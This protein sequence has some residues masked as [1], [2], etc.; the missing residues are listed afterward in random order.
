MLKFRIVSTALLLRSFGLKKKHTLT[1]LL[2]LELLCLHAIIITLLLGFEIFFGLLI[3][4]VGACEGAVGLGALVR[5]IRI[6]RTIRL[7]VNGDHFWHIRGSIH[8]DM[9][10]H[11]VDNRGELN[12]F[13]AL[14]GGEM[15]YEKINDAILYCAK[16]W[17]SD[18]PQ[19]RNFKRSRHGLSE[20]GS[21]RYATERKNSAPSL[22]RL[23]IGP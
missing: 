21:Y 15:G 3:V 20:V 5:I 9:T 4:C 19:G 22:L 16:C 2:T 8:G 11:M 1:V 14:I 17:L 23:I 10:G 7:Y 12:V 13:L 18:H 6:G